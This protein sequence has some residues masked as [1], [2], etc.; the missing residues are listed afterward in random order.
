MSYCACNSQKIFKVFIAIA[1]RFLMDCDRPLIKILLACN[2][3]KQDPDPA[4]YCST[5]SHP[6]KTLSRK[7]LIDEREAIEKVAQRLGIEHLDLFSDVVR[8]KC[9][10]DHYLPKVTSDLC[11]THK[12][13]PLYDERDR[14][15]V[16]FANPLDIDAQQQLHFALGTSLRI[17]IA[18]E[19]KITTLLSK[20]YP[21]PVSLI[22]GSDLEKYDEQVEV[23]TSQSNDDCNLDDKN[24]NAAPV[25]KL[26]NHMLI[27]GLR[28]RASDIH[29]D[30]TPNGL[31]VR[32]RIDGEMQHVFDTPKRFQRPV[33]SRIKLLSGMNIAERRAPQDGRFRIKY[34][35][36]LVDLRVSCLPTAYGEK[37]VI[38][39]LHSDFENLSFGRLGIPDGIKISL[40][41]DLSLPSR[42][43]LVT[44]PTGSGKTTT[45]YAALK[46][47]CD[48]TSNIET[49]EDPIEYKIA[50]VNRVQINEAAHVTFAS[51]L[52]SILRQDPDV[53]MVGEIRDAET[54]NIAL[55]AAQ[56]GHL[57]LSTLHTNDAPSAVTRLL[58]LGCDP[59]IISSSL[60]G[61]M[62][63]RLVRR[64]CA[65]CVTSL[66]IENIE[67]DLPL[68][69]QYKIDPT[70]LHHGIG[71]ERCR[72]T[73]YSGRVGI[74]SYF[75]MS[76]KVGSLIH[77]GASMLDIIKEAKKAG[78]V[79]LDEAALEHL[80]KGV[81]TFSEIKP[82]LNTPHSYD[83]DSAVKSQ[84]LPSQSSTSQTSSAQA[85]E[86]IT[87]MVVEDDAQNRTN[88][89]QHLRRKHF[90]VI[91]MENGTAAL[92]H[93]KETAPDL[94]ITGLGLPDI[95]GKQLLR[96]AREESGMD[97]V[98]IVVLTSAD[99][100][101]NEAELLRLGADDFISRSR[102]PDVLIE[103]VE[104]TL[105]HRTHG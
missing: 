3:L 69:S 11:L 31:D 6:I 72:Y 80:R 10:I 1:D 98:P 41:K 48:G 35:E 70:T 82:F 55:Q 53:I 50:G 18:E 87:V 15:V 22:G 49:V 89:A 23:V 88:I 37:I 36:Q 39:I 54:A 61:I 86:R 74:Y 105:K 96:L 63:Q 71:C 78:F 14:T 5:S 26:I 77:S 17:V 73:G 65:H 42:M 29:F 34:E 13:I 68:F 62:A 93:L 32:Y 8:T 51:C 100:D 91:E 19:D 85:H 44:G 76:P 67:Q 7:G 103:R 28:L 24:E 101:E 27:E 57:V 81:T 66:P 79:D 47:L 99:S 97:K 38:R 90:R 16:A 64:I 83:V 59:F 58:N 25:I 33:V 21:S 9:T 4:I 102:S 40:E 45:L 94:I 84:T 12:A 2:C 52:R 60:A 104:R 95:D 56:T 20:H 75:H 92:R 30:A 43:V 46:F